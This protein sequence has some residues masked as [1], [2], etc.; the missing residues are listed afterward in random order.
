M[1][2]YP[3]PSEPASSADV[4]HLPLTSLFGSYASQSGARSAALPSRNT[5]PVVSTYSLNAHNGA[6]AVHTPQFLYPT[7]VKCLHV[8]HDSLSIALPSIPPPRAPAFDGRIMPRATE[9]QRNQ[10]GRDFAPRGL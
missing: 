5:C 8:P 7:S 6:G 9:R 4:L 1:C 2:H 10:A 3:S